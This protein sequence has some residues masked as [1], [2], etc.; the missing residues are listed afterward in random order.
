[1]KLRNFGI[2]AALNAMLCA[3][4][5]ALGQSSIAL[6]ERPIR[7]VEVIAFVEKQFAE[8]DTNHDGQVSA[9][10]FEAYRA[11]Q[12]EEAK[13]GLGHIGSHW[14]E[15]TDVDGNRRVSLEEAVSRPLQ[16]F[17]MADMNHDGIASVNEQSMAQ[18][19]M[20]K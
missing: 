1:M 2:A 9:S 14:L 3:G 7:R 15:K 17:D 6:G 16:L 13:A 12:P 19:L 18:L 11:R 20:G 4:M 8:M 10:E 5:P